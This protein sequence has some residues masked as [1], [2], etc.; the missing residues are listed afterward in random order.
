MIRFI[1]LPGMRDLE[2]AA[3]L[4]TRLR[5]D[6]RA[7]VEQRVEPA[8]RKLFAIE[9]E[10]EPDAPDD[11]AGEN[12]WRRYDREYERFAN[13]D[14]SDW[15]FTDD[16]GRELLIR[17]HV[18][19]ACMLVVSGVKGRMPDMEAARADAWGAGLEAEAQKFQRERRKA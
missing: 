8:M 14:L 1:D 5:G 18:R 6:D 13:A 4:H 10:I 11:D 12:A 17:D 7:F 16:H 2:N 15:D 19:D 3:V 9:G